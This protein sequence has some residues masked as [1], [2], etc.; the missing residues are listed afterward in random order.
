MGYP[1]EKEVKIKLAFFY[2]ELMC[3]SLPIRQAVLK[4]SVVPGTSA[5][6]IED[7]GNQFIG[8]IR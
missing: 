4:I 2:Y 8:L 7:A 5:S 1:M 6:F 3:E